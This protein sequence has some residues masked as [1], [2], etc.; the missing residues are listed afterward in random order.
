M[1]IMIPGG[2]PPASATAPSSRAHASSWSVDPAL[3]R[4]RHPGPRT[5]HRALPGPGS[6]PWPGGGGAATVGTI[7]DCRSADWLLLSLPPAR[8]NRPWRRSPRGLL[9]RMVPVRAEPGGHLGA[10]RVLALGQGSFGLCI[11]AIGLNASLRICAGAGK[12]AAGD[13]VRRTRRA[14]LTGRRPRSWASAMSSASAAMP[15]SARRGAR[16]A[17]AGSG[18]A[19]CLLDL[20]RVRNRRPSSPA[21][22][23][24]ASTR[25]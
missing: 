8:W 4:D 23:A 11:P 10:D 2:A 15:R 14:V 19:R 16:L 9:R 25:P 6:S 7:A 12:L 1:P 3:P 5:G 13:A 24:T 22:R 17:G 21:A 18:T 20:R